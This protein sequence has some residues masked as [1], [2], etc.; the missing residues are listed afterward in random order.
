MVKIKLSISRPDGT[1]Q[2]MEVEGSRAQQFLSKR[3]GEILEGSILGL[4]GLKLQ[5][6]GGSDKD[7]FPMRRDVHGGVRKAIMVSVG[8]GFRTKVKGKRRRKMI[9]GNIITDD[10]VQVNLKVLKNT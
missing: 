2:S 4:Q 10:I 8:T 9:R 3:M 5:I 7:G 1:A 6:T